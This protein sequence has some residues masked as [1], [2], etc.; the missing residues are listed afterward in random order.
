MFWCKKCV[1]SWIG[2]RINQVKAAVNLCGSQLF[3]DILTLVYHCVDRINSFLLFR[4]NLR[5]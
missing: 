4:F 2:R 3:A 1:E 5:Y